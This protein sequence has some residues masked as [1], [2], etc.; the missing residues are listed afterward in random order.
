MHHTR[1]DPCEVLQDTWAGCYH[2]SY[3]G[4]IV[5]EAFAHPAKMAPGLLRHIFAHAKAEGWLK[6]NMVVLDPFMG[7]GTTALQ[8]LL[9]GCAFAGCELEPRFFALAQDNIAK[10]MAEYRHLAGWGPWA[11]L[12]NGDSRELTRLL[13]G[14]AGAV[15]SSPPYA[16]RCSNDNQRTIHR[17]GLQHGHNEG[18]GETYGSS[19][20]QL[21]AMV[22]SS[23]PYSRGTVHDKGQDATEVRQRGIAQAAHKWGTLANGHFESEAYGTTP[24]QLG[25]LPEGMR[26][27]ASHQSKDR[28]SYRVHNNLS[29]DSV[30]QS[31]QTAESVYHEAQDGACPAAESIVVNP[32]QA[33]ATVDAVSVATPP[34]AA[35]VEPE[36]TA[37]SSKGKRSRKHTSTSS[38]S[39]HEAGAQ[40]RPHE[41]SS[42]SS[43]AASQNNAPRILPTGEALDGAPSATRSL[44]EITM[45]ASNV[46][47]QG[48][49]SPSIISTM[50]MSQAVSGI[51]AQRICKPSA[52]A[53]ISPTIPTATSNVLNA[54]VPLS[55]NTFNKSSAHASVTSIDEIDTNANAESPETFWR[56]SRVI[57]EQVYSLLEPG[58]HAIWVVKDYV[59]AGK[60]VQFCD[61]WRKLCESCGF[62]TL[63][64]HHALLTETHGTQTTLFGGDEPQVTAKKS[65]FRRLA[66]RRGSPAIDYETVLCMVKPGREGGGISCAISSP[67]YAE[68]LGKTHTYSDLTKAQ[69]DNARAILS[70]RALAAPSYGHTPGQLGA[71][72]AGSIA[73]VI[74]SPPY[75]EGLGKEHT[76]TDL[77]KTQRHTSQPIYTERALAT[78]SYGHTA[79]Q[80]GAMK[81]GAMPSGD[82]TP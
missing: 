31:A 72:K 1:K 56:A 2:D 46:V 38:V 24:G 36:T 51:T 42:D 32:S 34:C 63:H 43:S 67:P 71:M 82:A 39:P 53:A 44:H 69:R 77:A 54:E 5:P 11:Y 45:P 55:V 81:A 50:P 20:G 64:E 4:L 13:P 7:I 15:V 59:R 19:P 41:T 73:C 76:Y 48:E 30:C 79:G 33:V 3:A 35:N 74:S 28:M 47:G 14:M 78:P 10:W 68:A 40:Q 17:T 60:R 18:D 27:P 9:H 57:V 21:A 29:G 52:G 25:I 6:P 65:F 58:G 80:L 66:E 37:K 70:E 16:D 26:D 23:P 49:A 61:A 22:C 62:I 12:V 75:A 8:A